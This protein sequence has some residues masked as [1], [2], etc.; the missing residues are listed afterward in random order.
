MPS[1]AARIGLP[2]ALFTLFPGVSSLSAQTFAGLG[3]R[4]Q[5]MAGAFVAVA[6][7]ASAIYWNPAGL[8][9]PTGAIFDAQIG[10]GE[11]RTLATV[12]LPSLGISF[13]RLPIVSP[14]AGRQNEGSGKV[15]I[16]TFSTLNMGVT[17]NQTVV[18][19][20][21]IGSTIRVTHGG[22]EGLAAR[23]TV[24]FDGGAIFS[25]SDFRVG[26]TGRNLL[27]PEYQSDSGVF[28]LSRQVRAGV[29][30]VPRSLPTGVH[31]PFSVA[32]DADLTRTQAPEGER[33]DAAA[34]AEYWLAGG[35]FGVRSGIRW[36]TLT[37]SNVALSGGAT[38]GLPHSA[39]V[40]GHLTKEQDSDNT[41]WGI[42]ARFTF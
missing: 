2:L 28:A 7:D 36:S 20:L 42:G 22:F 13:Y 10:V 41:E 3:E 19:A 31:G 26:L 21:V 40:E 16:R 35:K 29:A 30:Y 14:S 27:R 18:N 23:T 39:F 33:R 1:L 25:A 8:G 34:G 11:D 38:V 5:G 32:F 37:G 15:P 9:W 24:D 17:V 6:D 12:A 4:A